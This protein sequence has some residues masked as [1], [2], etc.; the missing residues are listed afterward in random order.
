[1]AVFHPWL[2]RTIAAL[3][4]YS[5]WLDEREMEPYRQARSPYGDSVDSALRWLDEQKNKPQYA[6]SLVGGYSCMKARFLLSSERDRERDIFADGDRNHRRNL[7]IFHP[8]VV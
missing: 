1:V 4:H 5:T 8:K 6:S 7:R 3:H 2:Y